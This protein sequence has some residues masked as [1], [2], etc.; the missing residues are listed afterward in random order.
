MAMHG[1][2]TV[3]VTVLTADDTPFV[4]IAMNLSTSEAEIVIGPVYLAEALV[5]VEPLV[6]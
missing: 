5:G 2:W 3:M 4:P 1:Y 6:V